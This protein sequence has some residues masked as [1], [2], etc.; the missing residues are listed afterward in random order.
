MLHVAIAIS[1]P[2][3]TYYSAVDSSKDLTKDNQPIVLKNISIEID[4]GEYVAFTDSLH[5]VFALLFYCTN[6]STFKPLC[7]SMSITS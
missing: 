4:R 5:A 3:F 6:I 1:D 7:F 2:H